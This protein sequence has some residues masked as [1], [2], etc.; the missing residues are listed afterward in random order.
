[1]KTGLLWFDDSKRSLEDKVLRAVAR[2]RRKH[3]RAPN[4]CLAH[5]EAFD[6]H[7]PPLAVG[8]VE[9]RA[10]GSILRCHFWIGV[11]RSSGGDGEVEES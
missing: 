7:E 9:V 4:L 10:D 3:G 8:E 5:P 2:Y 11:G 6:G 1:M